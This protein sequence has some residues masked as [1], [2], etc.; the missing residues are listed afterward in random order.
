MK[1][2]IALRNLYISQAIIF[3]FLIFAY[4]SWFP[5]SF[6]QLGGFYK[7]AWMLIFVDL[8]L[9]PLL[10]FLVYKENKKY[11]KFDIN[12]LLSIQLIAFI[13]GAYSLFLKH[14][15][16]AVFSIDRFVLTNVSNI[17]PRPS[18][19]EQLN[20]Y[21]FSSPNFVV[22]NLPKEIKEHNDL[23]LDVVF[24]GQPDIDSR[25][26]YFTPLNQ[27][28]K[29]VME[30][31]IN[32]YHLIS[33]NQAEQKLRMFSKKHNGNIDDYA[34]FPMSGNNKKDVI[35]A[36]DRKTAKPVGIIDINPWK[37]KVALNLEKK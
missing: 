1:I 19:S 15:A 8:V 2:K 34:Y 26:K 28:A 29:T 13:F 6:T 5:H 30:K 10:V 11:L 35:W 23:M 33:N 4:F 9:G 20:S 27:H 21:F 12:V 14:P 25:P 18:W 32:I 3:V 24:K 22:A 16:Y 37:L 17:Y 7:T 36:F 31:G